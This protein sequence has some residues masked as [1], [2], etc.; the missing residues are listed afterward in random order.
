MHVSQKLPLSMKG[1]FCPLPTQERSPF[2]LQGEL[3]P[4]D[5]TSITR[6]ASQDISAIQEVIV[7]TSSGFR[8]VK[9]YGRLYLAIVTVV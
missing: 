7:S 9:Q 5:V 4:A 8:H 6:S 3:P 2:C 1:A